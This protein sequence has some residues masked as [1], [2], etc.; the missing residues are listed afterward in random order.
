MFFIF[1]FIIFLLSEVST[2]RGYILWRDIESKWTERKEK[3]RNENKHNRLL[4]FRSRVQNKHAWWAKR[5]CILSEFKNRDLRCNT[6]KTKATRF[7]WSREENYILQ[8][9]LPLMK[10]CARDSSCQKTSSSSCAVKFFLI[11]RGLK[12]AGFGDNNKKLK[13]IN[14]EVNMLSAAAG[15]V[16]ITS[17]YD[18]RVFILSSLSL[19]RVPAEVLSGKLH[20]TPDNK[21]TESQRA[22]DRIH[23][24]SRMKWRTQAW[25][26]SHASSCD[27][28]SHVQKWVHCSFDCE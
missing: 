27:C 4:L 16:L 1:S 2:I 28:T 17:A 24:W 19:R 23:L 18:V 6:R 22:W 26:T 8:T 25:L 3:A 12:S 10:S 7:V 9:C 15:F 11:K 21:S 5:V 20:S 13:N 14:C